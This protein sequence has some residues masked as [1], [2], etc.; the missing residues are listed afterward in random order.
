LSVAV[1]VKPPDEPLSE[2][3]MRTMAAVSQTLADQNQ[4][5]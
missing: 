5:Q 4:A 2:E 3:E 1:Q